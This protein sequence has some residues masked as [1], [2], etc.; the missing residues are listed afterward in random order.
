MT[1]EANV[2]LIGVVDVDRS[3]AFYTEGLGW[4]IDQDHGAFVAFTP[5]AGSSS[6]ALYQRDA[7]AGD[8]GVPPDGSGFKA[9]VFNHFV[10]NESEVDSLLEKARS[11]GGEIAKPA[12]QAQWGGYFGYFADPDGHLWK[13]VAAEGADAAFAE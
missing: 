1:V 13:V 10:S 3:K 5:N 12:Q 7:L 8:A 11:A 9:V 4:T 2:I 6:F